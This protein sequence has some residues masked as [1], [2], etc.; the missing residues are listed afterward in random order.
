[1]RAA[2]HDPELPIPLSGNTFLTPSKKPI[3]KCNKIGEYFIY[4]SGRL[5]L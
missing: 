5:D 2:Y 1:M 3:I 4:F